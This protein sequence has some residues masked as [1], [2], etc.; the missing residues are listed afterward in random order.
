MK[1]SI[2]VPVFNEEGNV[3]R[4]Y[5][6]TSPVL[7]GLSGSSEIIFIDDGSRDK[8][9]EELSQIA[10]KDSRVRIIRLGRNFGQTAAMSAGF[11]HATGDVVIPMDADLQNDPADIPRLLQKINDGFDV[12]SGWRK[13]RKDKPLTRKFPSTIANW[14]IG[15]ITGIRLHDYGCTLKAYR[16]SVISG[17]RLYGEMHRFIPAYAAWNGAR[18]TEIEVT[19]HP[20][21]IGKSKYT[22]S[23]T[24]KVFL[25]LIVVKFL[26]TYLARPIHFFGFIGLISI[27]MGS[28][29]GVLALILKIFYSVSFIETPLPLLTVF[30]L[31][32][33]VQFILLGLIAEMLTRTYYESQG[34]STYTI[35]QKVNF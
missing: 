34:K 20:R 4:L 33:G 19:H 18:V 9:F 2:L 16:R 22:L 8:S 31:L 32:L 10:Q 13:N 17:I 7:D 29:S 30:L 23:R 21:T 28:L 6:A 14:L 35:V 27:F 12:V 15:V 25:D 26:T 1:Y 3:G 11:E 5:N 24:I